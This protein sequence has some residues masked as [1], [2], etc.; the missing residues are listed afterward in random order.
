MLIDGFGGKPLRNS[1]IVVSQRVELMDRPGRSRSS[2]A[3]Q[4]SL[5]RTRTAQHSNKAISPQ[6]REEHEDSHSQ[7]RGGSLCS[8]CLCAEDCILQAEPIGELYSRH[9]LLPCYRL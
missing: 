3:L 1:V 7:E 9:A 2:T 8:S 4:V 5:P 6:R